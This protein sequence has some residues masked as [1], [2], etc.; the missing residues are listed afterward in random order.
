M[1]KRPDKGDKALQK[2]LNEKK[3]TESEVARE[4]NISDQK[5]TLMTVRRHAIGTLSIIEKHLMAYT[6]KC[7]NCYREYG[8]I[9]KCV[10]DANK[11]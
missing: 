1:A 11:N 8:F 7:I 3:V 5:E 10:C 4:Q 9:T 6:P 2:I